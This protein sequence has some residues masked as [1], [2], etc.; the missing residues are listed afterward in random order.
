MNH[1]LIEPVAALASAHLSDLS[2]DPLLAP[3]PGAAPC[4]EDL[5][6]SNDFD[7]I[8]RL[9]EADDPSLDQGEWVTPLKVA[10]WPGVVRR[11]TELL[12]QRSKDLR[13]ASWL[14]EALAFTEGYPGLARGLRLTAQLAQ[15]YWL[16]LHPLP[17]GGDQEER[18][19]NIAWLL[20]R[21]RE[22]ARRLPVVPG[23]GLSDSLADNLAAAQGAVQ[24]LGE[25]Q[26]VIDLHLGAHG[27][28]FVAAREALVDA[29]ADIERL[30][31]E[32]GAWVDASA[33]A[34]DRA[35]APISPG[36]WA[37]AAQ[38]VDLGAGPITSRAQALQRL[39]EVAEYFRRAE[40]HSP[41]AY[42]AD[43][44]VQWGHMPLHEWLRVVLK[45]AGSLSHV[46]ELLGVQPRG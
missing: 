12:T 10:D 3:I 37:A 5:S 42:L 23:K 1:A 16:Y 41:V 36:E 8:A 4:G 27:P 7:A 32:S 18:I 26:Q 43:K 29:V 33:R 15:R 30:V 45:D 21:V 31:R 34:T 44:A 46:E 40:P 13:L 9:R 14:T 35:T 22:Q 28:S 2:T 20:A 11:S 24:A 6:Y 17:E 25:L 39:Q 19:G 38:Q